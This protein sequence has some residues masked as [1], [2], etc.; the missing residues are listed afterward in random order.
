MIRVLQP[1]LPESA[2]VAPYLRRIDAARIYSNFG[3]LLVEFERRLAGL[4]EVSDDSVTCVANGTLALCLALKAQAPAPG[5]LCL[6]PSW[7][8]AA[9]AHAATANGQVPYFV[10][11]RP[12]TWAIDPTLASEAIRSAPGRVG[13]VVPVVPFGCPFDYASWDRFAAET[14]IAVAIDAAAAF[15]TAEP[16]E[17]PLVLSMHAT[18]CFGIGEG[19]AVLSRNAALVKKIRQMS[20]FGFLPGT[21]DALF[22]AINAKLS[23]YAASVA[24]A[25][26]DG[27]PYTRI[28]LTSLA[29]AYAAS[30]SA[31]PG[32]GPMP[33]LDGTFAGSTFNIVL[34]PEL[35]AVSDVAARLAREGIETRRWWGEGCHAQPA[36]TDCPRAD[37]LVTTDLARGSLGLPFHLGIGPREINIVVSTLADALVLP[38]QS[39]R[40]SAA[41]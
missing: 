15:D 11:V 38:A 5:S 35:P 30:L 23:E 27:W 41:R 1:R 22:P 10:D 34:D 31:L 33:G 3:P 28:G 20:C 36:F 40:L 4:F 2:L 26:L 32:V 29:R 19:G 37:L 8:F 14:G 6:M 24:L 13:A 18:K 25:T 16:G 12:E 7:T 39:A 17:T 21:R 9:T